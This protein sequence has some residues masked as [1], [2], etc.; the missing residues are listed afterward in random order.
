MR[1]D[2]LPIHARP[3]ADT[4]MTAK[5]QRRYSHPMS[6]GAPRPRQ[7]DGRT[8]AGRLSNRTRAEA[9]AALGRR[10]TPGE[11]MLIEQLAALR[12]RLAAIAQS[13]ETCTTREHVALIATLLEVT[14]RLGLAAGPAP[15]PAASDPAAALRRHLAARPATRAPPAPARAEGVQHNSPAAEPPQR[16]ILGAPLPIPAEEAAR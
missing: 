1:H 11:A 14:R 2:T 10:P 8:L 9:L 6:P 15:D 4:G 5:H 12:V 13:P 7:L 3:A 16:P